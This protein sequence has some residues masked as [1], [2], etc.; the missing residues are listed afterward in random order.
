MKQHVF[1]AIFSSKL[2]LSGQPGVVYLLIGYDSLS[3]EVSVG[4]IGQAVAQLTLRRNAGE[5][6]YHT[7]E[8]IEQILANQTNRHRHLTHQYRLAPIFLLYV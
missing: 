4:E 3:N 7:F 6:P 2:V 8:Q 5:I 1:G